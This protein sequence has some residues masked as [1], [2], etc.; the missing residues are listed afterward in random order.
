MKKSIVLISVLILS[1]LALT[2]KKTVLINEA[3]GKPLV[4]VMVFSD[5]DTLISDRSGQITSSSLTSSPIVTYNNIYINSD[6]QPDTLFVDFPF[7]LNNPKK[8]GRIEGAVIDT[9]GKQ[10]Y[11]RKVTL[12]RDGFEY[13][14]RSVSKGEYFFDFLADGDWE[15]VVEK[16]EDYDEYH[17]SIAVNGF[18]IETISHNIVLNEH[19]PKYGTFEATVL[20]EDGNPTI[21]ASI[22]IVG[23]TKGAYIK[24][25][26]V[27]K[28]YDLEEGV[29]KIKISYPGYVSIYDTI[30]IEP[31][32]TLKKEYKLNTFVS[33]EIQVDHTND[34]LISGS[35]GITELDEEVLTAGASMNNPLMPSRA[36]NSTTGPAGGDLVG[37]Y[38]DPLIAVAAVKSGV[39]DDRSTLYD[40]IQPSKASSKEI[41]IQ[42]GSLTAGE[43]NDFRKWE[44]WADIASDELSQYIDVWGIEPTKRYTVQLTSLD[45]KP[46]SDAVVNLISQTGE[47]IWSA[48]SDN[49][50]KAELWADAYKAIKDSESGLSVEVI[51]KG[52]RQIKNSISDFKNGINFIKVNEY[53]SHSQNVDIVF[54]MDATGSMGDEIEYLKTELLDIIERLQKTQE[55]KNLRIGSIFY[56]D[57]DYPFNELITTHDLTNDFASV[58]EFINSQKAISGN[59]TA[60][61]VEV[62]LSSAVNEFTWSE[63]A[64]A[65]IMFLIL[66]APP[67][68]D[69]QTLER[70]RELTARASA[71]GIRIIPLTASG[72]DKS[73]EYLMR[74]LALLTNGTYLFLTDDS[75][76]G[77]SHIKPT[78]DSYDVEMMNEMIVRIINQFIDTP[79]CGESEDLYAKNIN[80]NIYNDKEQK[81]ED[82]SDYIRIFPNPTDGPV[83]LELDEQYDQMFV[84][85]MN[86]KILFRIEPNGSRLQINLSEFPSGA[87]FL[88]YSYKGVWGGSQIRLMR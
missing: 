29:H 25:D 44:M 11:S 77:G 33:Y 10:L 84:V 65:R 3:N 21:A 63:D 24:A 50:G 40:P 37:V 66:D 74:S 31:D 60:E 1:S 27:G 68:E 71:M 36:S 26:G 81:D 15:I 28:I 83:T 46:V 75:G 8:L 58:N 64:V 17:E 70:F 4:G 47:T 12:S 88:K 41:E 20:D 23:T 6:L 52:K 87:Y 54:A 55:E 76:I 34:K 57:F 35:R 86:G 49:T 39:Y 45:N 19:E 14:T 48:R 30:T 18:E 79:T 22:L 5:K 16:T 9:S 53:C 2:A 80:D 78:T 73:S 59:S 69:P 82:I 38:P 61:A 51:Y 43:V 32:K 62:A 56:R 7:T 42:A 72:I 13:K 67:H 85:D